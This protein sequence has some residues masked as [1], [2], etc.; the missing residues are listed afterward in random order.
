[1]GGYKDALFS[2][3]VLNVINGLFVLPSSCSVFLCR[4]SEISK[5]YI[6]AAAAISSESVL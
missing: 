4:D 2:S 5:S 6:A 1:M 3:F